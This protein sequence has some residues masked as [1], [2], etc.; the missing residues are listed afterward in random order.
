MDINVLSVALGDGYVSS[1]HTW[2]TNPEAWNATWE[3]NLDALWGKELEIPSNSS[4][5]PD[6]LK[7]LDANW[8]RPS[9]TAGRLNSDRVAHELVDLN[10]TVS[11]LQRRLSHEDGLRCSQDD[12]ERAWSE[13]SNAEQRKSFLLKGFVETLAMGEPPPEC[14][15]MWCPELT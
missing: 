8:L 6:P 5:V 2:Q 10:K 3:R 13:K 4:A 11:L 14:I 7:R 9:S 12:F 1:P 15:R